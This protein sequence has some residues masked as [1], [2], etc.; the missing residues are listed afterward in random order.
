GRGVGAARG[1]G[2]VRG[3]DPG[4][5]AVAVDGPEGRGGVRR[6]R[7]GP[8][9]LRAERQPR[10]GHGGRLDRGRFHDGPG[11]GVARGPGPRPDAAV[12]NA[13]AG[14]PIDHVQLVERDR[15]DD[16]AARDRPLLPRAAGRDA[17]TAAAP[18]VDPAAERQAQVKNPAPRNPGL[19]PARTGASN[20]P[21]MSTPAPGRPPR[22]ALR[23]LP[24]LACALG[25]GLFASGARAQT[26]KPWTPAHADS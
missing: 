19:T 8:A 4:G 10:L 14:E 13:G 15:S 17:V 1:A 24:A 11:R 2:P 18:A 20:R 25:F 26:V 9:V 16:A 5:G 22:T 3:H 23:Q 12:R 21:L 6:E 7:G